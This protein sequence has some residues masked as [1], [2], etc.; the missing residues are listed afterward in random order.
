V[1]IDEVWPRL[2][3][4]DRGKDFFGY[5]QVYGAAANTGKAKCRDIV[6]LGQTCGAYSGSPTPVDFSGLMGM[7][8]ALAGLS[9][10]NVAPKGRF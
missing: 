6:A 5:T 4:Q 10:H 7:T 1:V 9:P 8:L 3:L 2:S